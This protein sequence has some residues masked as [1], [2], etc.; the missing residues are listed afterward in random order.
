M[1]YHQ[2]SCTTR[3]SFLR[4]GD[5]NHTQCLWCGITMALYNKTSPPLNTSLVTMQH[6]TYLGH[7]LVHMVPFQSW[8]TCSTSAVI[9]MLPL[10]SWSTWSPSTLG[11]YGLQG[12]ITSA[13]FLIHHKGDKYHLSSCWEASHY[14]HRTICSTH[15]ATLST[16]PKSTFSA[17][18]SRLSSSCQAWC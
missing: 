2:T 18:S 16:C 1:Y 10:C 17:S 6:P 15:L 5:Q 7:L 4:S 14:P 11:L 3:A 9:H 13:P 8:S 12:L